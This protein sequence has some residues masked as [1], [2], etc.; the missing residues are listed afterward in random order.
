ML[1]YQFKKNTSLVYFMNFK[2]YLF[3]KGINSDIRTK[4]LSRR[5]Y[6]LICD[7]DYKKIAGHQIQFNLDNMTI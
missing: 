5:D 4:G 1:E 7:C 6:A 3:N 2:W